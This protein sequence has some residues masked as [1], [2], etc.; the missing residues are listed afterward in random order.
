MFA[1]F[2]AELDQRILF[3]GY[4]NSNCGP[5]TGARADIAGAAGDAGAVEDV[6]EAEADVTATGAAEAEGLF[7]VEALTVVAHADAELVGE[8]VEADIDAGG[9]GMF[10][11]IV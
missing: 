4:L 3:V 9:P 6:L 5:F 10:E 8:P 2:P 11:T 1:K 7:R